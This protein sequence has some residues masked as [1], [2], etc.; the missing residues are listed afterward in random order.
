MALNLLLIILYVKTEAIFFPFD[1]SLSQIL[2]PSLLLRFICSS[3]FT[4]LASFKSSLLFKFKLFFFHFFPFVQRQ[5]F[6]IKLRNWNPIVLLPN[7]MYQVSSLVTFRCDRFIS[8][9]LFNPTCL[10]YC[11]PMYSSETGLPNTSS[12]T[13]L[14]RPPAYSSEEIFSRCWPM[15]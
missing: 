1:F 4:F 10:H 6:S 5:A 11:C 7:L 2:Y 13:L 15:A 3:L 12:R 14:C 8:V 9:L